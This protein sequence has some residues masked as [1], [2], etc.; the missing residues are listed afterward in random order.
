MVLSLAACGAQP[1][2]HPAAGPTGNRP[3]TQAHAAVLSSPAAAPSPT[4]EVFGYSIQHRALVDYRVGQPTGPVRLLV[5]GVIHGDET[6]GEPIVRKLL[7]S[8]Q[9]SSNG[10]LVVVPQLNPDGIAL[11]TRQNAR[12]VDLN[13]NFPYAWQRIGKPGDQQYSGTGPL[14]E[15]ESKAMAAL[16]RRLR[17]AVTVW[18]HQ[19]VNVVDLSGGS[20]AI[21]QRFARILGEPTKHITSYPGSAT[22]WQNHGFPSTTAFVV[23]LPHA[24][25]TARAAAAVRALLDLRR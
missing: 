15:P 1:T 13:R 8:W 7:R 17:P 23:E 2:T 12:R 22:R 18:F 25:T 9:P 3:A 19:P 14:S 4:R 16:I 24:V 11:H 21:E 6:A 10:A 20:A 5:V